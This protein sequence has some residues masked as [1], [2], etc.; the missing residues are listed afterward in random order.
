MI[1]GQGNAIIRIIGK[2]TKQRTIFI[3]STLVTQLLEYS[4]NNKRFVFESKMKKGRSLT[5][6]TIEHRFKKLAEKITIN[7]MNK[8]IANVV[9]T[10]V[11][12]S[13]S[14]EQDSNKE[15]IISNSPQII[16]KI[17][18]FF[19]PLVNKFLKIGQYFQN[20]LSKL[21]EKIQ[22][23]RSCIPFAIFNPGKLLRLLSFD[24]IFIMFCFL[25]YYGSKDFFAFLID[26]KRT[27][28]M[29]SHLLGLFFSLFVSIFIGGYFL[30]LLLDIILSITFKKGK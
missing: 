22:V 28:I 11:A 1:F 15:E 21:S 6:R 16:T 20:L 26:Q 8:G 24:N 7:D 14:T 4:R 23:Q 10:P 29:F 30:Q 19:E 27:G 2:N 25:F 18:I 17:K 12:I 5:T 13:S 9:N 3:P